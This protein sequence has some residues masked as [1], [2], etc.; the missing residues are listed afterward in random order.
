MHSNAQW[1]A[2][3]EKFAGACDLSKSFLALDL[4]GTA[5]LEDHGKV[6]ISSSVEKGVRAIHDLKIPV[7]LNT[8]R[9]PLSVITTVGHAWYEIAD[10]PILTVLL[11][12][13]VLGYIKC[14]DGQLHY[15]EIAA[16]PLSRAEITQI[17]EGLTQLAQANIEDVLLFFYS[18][19]WK[20]GEI[21]WTPKA[22]KIPELQKKY[23]S[24]SRVTS[25]PVE[26]LG[27]EL[28]RREVCMASL[29]INRPQD[30]L[31]AY[32]HSKRSSFFTA[33]GINKASGLRAISAKL[34]LAPA[35]ALGAG[36]TE[37][38]TFLSEVGFAVI[39]GRAELPFRGQKE[40]TRVATP[41]ELGDLVQAYADLLKPSAGV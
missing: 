36:D 28:S 14:A 12:G 41:V 10:V 31:M 4:D 27:E 33:K 22:D 32:Q 29:F 30:T 1:F 37:M 24:A 7:V 11:N 23:V 38:D 6:F 3:L 8:L 13:S 20:E 35:E 40:T 9:F 34:G 16:Y 26:R 25:G 18:R 15:E 39:V 2:S 19:D 21:L 5:L 17:L